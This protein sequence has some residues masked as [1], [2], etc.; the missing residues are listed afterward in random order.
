VA[1]E[2][3]LNI[4]Y[5]EPDMADLTQSEA[6]ALIRVRKLFLDKTPL[7]IGGGNIQRELQSQIRAEERF[8]LNIRQTAI[9]F[10]IFSSVTRFFSQPLVRICIDKDMKHENPNGEIIEGSH[11]HLYREGFRD[12]FA[13]PLLKYGFDDSAGIIYCLGKFL[14]IC[15]IED[16]KINQQI[17]L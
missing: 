4:L 11:I 7:I 10:G 15:N 17:R 9:E 8:Y 6:D 13:T 3:F 16:I 14:E 12:R 2:K 1:K 5:K